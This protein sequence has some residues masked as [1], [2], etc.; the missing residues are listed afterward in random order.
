MPLLD[1]IEG[2]SGIPLESLLGRCVAILGVRG[3][4]KTNTATV[5]VE[6][7]LRY[8]IP[9]TIVD[10]EDEYYGLLEH[11]DILVVGY[12][13][14][15]HM[16][17]SPRQAPALARMSLQRGIPVTLSFLEHPKAEMFEFLDRYLRTL[18]QE[19]AKLRRPYFVVMEEAHEFVP[20]HGT[21]PVTETAE[22][23]TL[24][25]RKRGLATILVSQRSA[26]VRKNVLTQADAYFLHRVTHP[27][28][29]G[30]YRQIVA[31][32]PEWVRG[33]LNRA[34]VGQAM[35]MLEGRWRIVRIREQHCF[36]AG[37]TPGLEWVDPDF[38]EPQLRE[39][40]AFIE[41]FREALQDEEAQLD[42]QQALVQG[43]AAELARAEA[44]I[45][46]L[47]DENERLRAEL[48]RASR[49]KVEFPKDAVIRVGRMIVASAVQGDVS[50][51][52][53]FREESRKAPSKKPP[54][55]QLAMFGENG[56]N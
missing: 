56:D 3:S 55:E 52:R 53:G 15:C 2:D 29:Q 35:M 6:E 50:S 16:A 4:G 8:G 10:I 18:W 48:A 28:D 49:I 41:A 36:H 27:T 12:T 21:T 30:V 11:H 20:L 1:I 14:H 26:A 42:P 33:F 54:K 9:L 37:Y 38:G 46:K 19:E 13:E 31:K 32:P 39:P 34:Q 45:E 23:M 44:A 47:K 24:R 7:L 5:L 51:L 25:G 40:V 22:R 17:A 43:L